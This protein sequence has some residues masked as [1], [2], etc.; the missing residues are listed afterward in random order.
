MG[1]EGEGGNGRVWGGVEGVIMGYGGYRGELWGWRG[2]GMPGIGGG[3]LEVMG[4]VILGGGSV[5]RGLCCGV[6]GGG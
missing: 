1:Y 6:W 5:G 3:E 2:R 4:V